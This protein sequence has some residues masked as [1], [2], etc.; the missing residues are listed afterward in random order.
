MNLK[1]EEASLAGIGT[2]GEGARLVLERDIP[3]GDRRNFAFLS[4]LIT[5]GAARD[6]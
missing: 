4:T 6:W 3:L 1:I 5:Y 2:S